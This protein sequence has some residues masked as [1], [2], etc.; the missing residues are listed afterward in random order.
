MRHFRLN[1]IGL[2]RNGVTGDRYR[3]LEKA[4]RTIRDGDKTLADAPDT[5]EIQLL[6]DWLGQKSKYGLLGFAAPRKRAVTD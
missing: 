3:A 5:E 2:K 1:T 4:F 6:R